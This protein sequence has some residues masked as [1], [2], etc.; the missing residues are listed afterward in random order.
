MIRTSVWLTLCSVLVFGGSHAQAPSSL[1]FDEPRTCSRQCLIDLVDEY[2]AALAAHDPRAAPLAPFTRFVE[3]AVPTPIGGGLW[4]T[5][6]G[7]PT[8]FKIYVPDSVSEQV[9]FIGVLEEEGV[10]VELGLRLR[11]EDGLITEAEH[12]VARNLGEDNLANLQT[13][14]P[15]LVSFLAPEERVSR[16]AML[17]IGYSYYVALQGSDG[18][19]APFADDCIRRENG[20]QTTGNSAPLPGEEIDFSVFGALG[21]AAQLNTR[22]MSYI[23]KIDDRRVEIADVETGLV[24]GLSHFRH[25]M[26]TK[27]LGIIGMPG[28]ETWDVDFDPFDLPAAHIFKIRDGRIHEI[29]AMG[30]MLPYDSPTG[31]E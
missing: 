2:L 14:R 18:S 22:V 7:V 30:V 12:L 8:T 11:V 25:P 29:E 5:A 13:P 15:G 23:K 10:P 19:A 16:A 6:S 1:G 9:G 24:F 27:T 20:R 21:C 4:R 26:E 31:W 17:D 3:N 28:V